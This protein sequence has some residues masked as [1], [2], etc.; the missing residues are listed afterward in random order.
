VDVALLGK[1]L[2]DMTVVDVS[3]LVPSVMEVKSPEEIASMRRAMELTRVGIETFYASLREGCVE[4]EV[5]LEC[6]RAMVEAGSERPE[7][8]EVLFGERTAVPHG[9]PGGK[10]LER[11]DVAFTELSG[12]FLGYC[13]ALARTAVLGPNRPV[14]GLHEVAQAALE[15][16]LNALRPGVTTGAVDAAC[17]AAVERAG[18]GDG[19]RHRAGYSH[20]LGWFGRGDLSLKP[21]G[22]D[23]IRP[24]MVLHLPI[25]LFERGAFGVACSETVLVTEDGA[26]PLSGLPRDLVVID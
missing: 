24:G 19:F 18:R 8:F 15:A 2:P 17:R 16:G 26:E 13:A 7:P 11:G 10:R 1:L 5:G 22:A 21:G 23:L 4:S 3:R 9:A 20:G 6:T 12:T 25:I 14:E